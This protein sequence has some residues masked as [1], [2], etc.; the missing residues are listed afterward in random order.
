MRTPNSIPQFYENTITD[1]LLEILNSLPV[2]NGNAGQ[3]LNGNLQ[4]S[5][6]EGQIADGTI[7][8]DMIFWDAHEIGRAH[9]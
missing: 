1:L 2:P 3:F 8:G 5:A 9:V 4:W 6:P 7:D